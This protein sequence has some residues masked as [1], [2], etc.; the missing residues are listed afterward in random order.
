M[1]VGAAVWLFWDSHTRLPVA[2]APAAP[3]QQ[4][5][6]PLVPA[7]QPAHIDEE[8]QKADQWDDEEVVALISRSGARHVEV[9]W[10]L[11]RQRGGD[12]RQRRQQKRCQPGRPAGPT[13]AGRQMA[14]LKDR[15]R[16]EI[17]CLS[18]PSPPALQC[19]QEL[20]SRRGMP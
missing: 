2:P 12:G 8:R 7:E 9:Q 18:A 4:A 3:Q 15:R 16:D 10:H 13:P 5:G 14:Q 11:S 19:F 1:R 20:T 17:D 6:H